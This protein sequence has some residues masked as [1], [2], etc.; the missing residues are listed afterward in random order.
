MIA[1]D[2]GGIL[3]WTQYVAALAVVVA[4]ALAV[5]GLFGSGNARGL[6][7]HVLLVPVLVWLAYAGF[8][9]IPLPPAVV[10][11]LSPASAAAYTDWVDPFLQPNQRPAWFPISIDPMATR[12]VVA[13]IAVVALALWT[14][15]VVLNTRARVAA[16]LS[17]IA[18][19]S[20]VHAAL[21]FWQLVDPSTTLLGLIDETHRGRFGTF[22]NRNNLALLLNFGTA[23]GLGLMS[24]RLAA[25]TG[26]ELDDP[27]FE[28]SDL[29][30]LISDRQSFVGILC[31]VLCSTGLLV[32][33]SRGGLA[34][35]LIGLLVA[36][37]WVRQRRGFIALPVVGTVVALCIAVLVIPTD[38]RLESI[39]RLQI[40]RPDGSVP[41]DAR[42]EHWPDGWSAAMAHLPAGSGS[43]TYAYAHLPHQ[44]A[45]SSG[46]FHHADNLWLELLVE[47]GVMG[48]LL[49]LL[50]FAI[51]IRALSHLGESSDPMDQGLRIAGWY[52]LAALLISQ[53][54]DFGLIVPSNLF[55]LTILAG[56]IIGR[57]VLAG[58]ALDD[59]PPRAA[60]SVFRSRR[61]EFASLALPCL[62]GL[63]VLPSV[64]QLRR[65]AIA[66][67]MQDQ[68][69][70][71]ARQSR[72]QPVEL[73]RLSERAAEAFAATPRAALADIHR[74][75]D[76][77]LHRFTDV[78]A[79]APATEQLAA[80]LYRQTDPRLRRLAWRAETD[81]LRARG[82]SMGMDS[83]H[84]SE[85]R[86]AAKSLLLRPLGREPRV[87]Q[88]LLDY[89]HQDPQRTR[90][91]IDQ[92]H[93]LYRGNADSLYRIGTFAADGG[94]Y[95]RAERI[96]RDALMKR[97]ALTKRVVDA[98]ADYPQIDL[99]S[100]LPEDRQVQR[101]AAA[102]LLANHETHPDQQTEALL[103][104]LLGKLACDQ[105]E[106]LAERS[107]CRMLAGDVA[108]HLGR[109]ERA[110]ENYAA[111][112]E[113]APADA[114]L[115]L[116]TIQRLKEQGRRDE[117]RR[118]AQVAV[119]RF[120]GDPK[121]Q[122]FIDQ[123]AQEDIEEVG[124]GNEE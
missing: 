108:Y 69:A 115:W 93:A 41:I 23:A 28:Y 67:R 111:A 117:A 97:P 54:F 123:M 57:T 120:P 72:T 82:V 11:L 80:Q 44:T 58:V 49:A 2:Y 104:S 6:K 90:A 71:A 112:R 124:I 100:V 40:I 99:Q 27:T 114:A 30:S 37:G 39:Q 96:W 25:L 94:D 51:L 118:Q 20:A 22:V 24:W 7:Q 26:Q 92:L 13:M 121:F 46:W 109:Y 52:A 31:V 53:I 91:A 89:V 5:P 122:G 86:L 81:P 10:G 16:L 15:T 73:Q 29:L 18:V 119:S 19:G 116:K 101:T 113:S 43:A 65:D 4:A 3:L 110:F 14:A 32:N 35:A 105:E 107:R 75:I 42:F 85:L 68:L 95:E 55:V 50:C 1:A 84:A 34:A 74:R 17:V 76:Q 47:H 62:L 106:T 77:Q 98:A 36:F 102:L 66:Q 79:A 21:G 87:A 48:V 78:I 33:G 61:S 83:P 59:E 64:N 70:S 88:V 12:H 9:A 103:Q 63:L 45:P 56:A 8:Q 38:M 60:T